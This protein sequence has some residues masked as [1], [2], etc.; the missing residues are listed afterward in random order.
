MKSINDFLGEGN[1]DKRFVLK[2]SKEGEE[3]VKKEADL[4]P[5]GFEFKDAF[6]EVFEKESDLKPLFMIDLYPLG[7]PKKNDKGDAKKKTKVG[8]KFHTK[9]FEA[10]IK[11][12]VTLSDTTKLL[13]YYEMHAK[14]F[15]TKTQQFVHKLDYLGPYL[16]AVLEDEFG[17]L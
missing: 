13:G 8:I 1:A 16:N 7:F 6:L 9:Q 11:L 10:K 4:K 3:E 2:Y 15:M 12:P 14:K 17:E 5:E